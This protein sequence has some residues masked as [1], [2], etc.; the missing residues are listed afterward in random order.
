M[1]ACLHP[2]NCVNVSTEQTRCQDLKHLTLHILKNWIVLYNYLLTGLCKR[3]NGEKF[4]SSFPIMLLLLLMIIF[5]L[6]LFNLY[7]EKNYGKPTIHTLL[8][9]LSGK[10]INTIFWKRSIYLE[11]R[12]TQGWNHRGK[13]SI[14]WFTIQMLI[15]SRVKTHSVQKPGASFWS[16]K[17]VAGAQVLGSPLAAFLGTW[18]GSR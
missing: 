10:H 16:P 7:Y 9:T 8:V 2:E 5:S 4:T 15:I 3:N 18:E 1:S 14:S 6:I 13:F 12:V 11:D 17:W